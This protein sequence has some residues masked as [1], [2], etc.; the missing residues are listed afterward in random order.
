MKPSTARLLLANGA[1]PNIVNNRGETPI[2]IAEFLQP[3]QKQEFLSIL[4]RKTKRSSFFSINSI[5]F[6][7][8]E[9]SSVIPSDYQSTNPISYV[10]PLL[11]NRSNWTLNS[12][13]FRSP[14][15]TNSSVEN[16]L[17]RRS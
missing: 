4:T 15:A 6:F 3:N 16:L 14:T 2:T 9:N 17:D 11:Q 10:C 1:N 12:D 7:L 8:E 13:E 5:E